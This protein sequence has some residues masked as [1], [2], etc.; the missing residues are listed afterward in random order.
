MGN[1]YLTGT[2]EILEGKTKD[3]HEKNSIISTPSSTHIR[4]SHDFREYDITLRPNHAHSTFLPAELEPTDP[5]QHIDNHFDRQKSPEKTRRKR[6]NRYGAKI[7]KHISVCI[8]ACIFTRMSRDLSK[9]NYINHIFIPI[10][11][12]TA[13]DLTVPP[14]EGMQSSL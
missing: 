10:L 13:A 8:H 9:K 11:N 6:Y 4:N 14:H 7:S 2:A 5:N 1:N 3:T 12:F